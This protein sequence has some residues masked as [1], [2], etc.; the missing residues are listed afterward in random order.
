[1]SSQIQRGLALLPFI[2]LAACAGKTVKKEELAKVH[3]VA[4]VGFDLQQQKSISAGDLVSIA[5]KQNKN[6]ATPHMRQESPHVDPIY[7]DL[8]SKLAAQT[9]WKVMS[10]E[11]V[12]NNAAYK[13]YL[14]E[15][16]EGMQ[17]RPII[18]DRFDLFVP[19]GIL[20]SFAILTTQGDRLKDLARDMGV[21]AVVFASSTINLNNDSFIM[22]MVGNGEFHPSSNLNMFVS[23]GRTA[24]KIF[25]D[26]ANGPKVDVGAKNAV[27]MANVDEL[28]LLARNATQLSLDMVLK[29]LEVKE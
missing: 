11:Q 15:K 9:G 6:E 22:S 24:E 26:S 5:L 19:A 25:M 28:N 3:K 8:T 4:V 27:G 13:K 10:L 17:N 14:A 18:N 16:S 2:L 21:D 1:M 12:K 29:D 23:D 7:H 20:D